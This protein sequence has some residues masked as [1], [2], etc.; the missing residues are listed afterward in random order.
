M[1]WRSSDRH[2]RD[3]Y[4]QLGCEQPR[5]RKTRLLPRDWR[6]WLLVIAIAAVMLALP[7]VAAL[8]AGTADLR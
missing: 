8:L 5:P 3:S 6:T 2:L 4:E 7:W 1:R